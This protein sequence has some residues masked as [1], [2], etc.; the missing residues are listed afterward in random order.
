[1][2]KKHYLYTRQLTT[3]LIFL[4][5]LILHG[6]AGTLDVTYGP[7]GTG[8]TTTAIGRSNTLTCIAALPDN[9]II[10]VGNVSVI[11]SVSGICKYTSLGSLDSSFNGTGYQQLSIGTTTQLQAVA[12]QAD[13]KAV[14]GGYTMNDI[15][16]F[17]LARFD[18]Q[19]ALDT[20]FG[21]TGYITTDISGGSSINAIIIQPD[22][23]IVAGGVAGQ[24][25]PGFALARYNTD[26]SLD[27][28]FGNNGTALLNL[29]YTSTIN[30]LA[31]QSDG[32]I[33]A[34]GFAWNYVTDIC[35]LARFNSDGS[36]DETFGNQGIVT[37]SIGMASRAEAVAIQAD[38]T[39]IIGGYTT[40]NRTHYSFALAR[41]DTNGNL[42]SSF[43][44]TGIVITHTNYSSQIQALAI[45]SDGNILAGGWNF[46][47]LA[48]Q[49]AL[50]RYLPSGLLD[51]TFGTQ[52]ITLTTIGA[53]AQI[54]SL[55]LQTDGAIIAA[56][57]SDTNAALARYLAN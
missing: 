30:A 27:Q 50:A 45:Q 1:M 38:G 35:A 10:G 14:V 37:T 56:G 17:A 23:K 26:G 2:Y 39:I 54:N 28:T 33:V 47:A 44:G 24:G 15:S 16:T 21:G 46:G 34:A 7:N 49:F 48:T 51:E 25:T 6:S 53:S 5:T 22:G 52:G 19:G 29:G 4:N 13:N 55:A 32:K 9:S 42:D 41:Y 20:T 40:N 43:N 11:D 31:L 3:A 57:S 12:L 18:T 8:I 36:V